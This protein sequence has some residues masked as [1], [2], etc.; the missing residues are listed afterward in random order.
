MSAMCVG[1]AAMAGVGGRGRGPMGISVGVREIADADS[2]RCAD[3]ACIDRAPWWAASPSKAEA[4]I[5]TASSS[6]S[7]PSVMHRPRVASD[8]DS[9]DSRMAASKAKR[10]C[11]LSHAT[12][13][14]SFPSVGSPSQTGSPLALWD[15]VQPS[16]S[17][18][19]SSVLASPPAPSQLSPASA[20]HTISSLPHHRR[21]MG[22]IHALP[23]ELLARIF[24]LGVDDHYA[25]HPDAVPQGVPAFEVLVS[26][27]CLHWRD[28]ALRTPSLWTHIHFR[29]VP[30]IARARLYLARSTRH[31]LHIFIDSAS[32]AD[33]VPGSSIFRD[34]FLPVCDPLLPHIHRWRSFVLK[35]RD[36]VCKG[37]ARTVLS[38][39]GPAPALD[40]LQLWHIEDW[41][42][43][44][45]LYTAIGPPPVVVF[46]GGL[47]A[48]RHLSLI[49]VNI[50]WE[51]R[52]SPFLARLRSLELALHSDDVR[53]PFPRWHAMLAA[54]PA[55][56]RL[57]LHYSGPRAAG[58]PWAARIRLDALRELCLTDLDPPYAC[59]LLRT[60]DA[61]ALRALRLELSDQ[62]FTPLAELLAAP[63]PPP[64]PGT[65]LDPA[66]PYAPWLHA[67]GDRA[68]EPAPAPMFPALRELAVAALECTPAAWRRLLA[69]MRAV[70]L[71]DADFR[72]PRL[73]P[74]FFDVLLE[75]L[76]GRG[77]DGR[78]GVG[79]DRDR[80]RGGEGEE[81]EGEGGE[82]GAG[83]GAR[84]PSVLLPALHTLRT[85][86]VPGARL[87]ALAVFR[88]QCGRP[89][90]RWL[91]NERGRDA[92][93]ERMQAAVD[94]GGEDGGGGIE[95][96]EWFRDEEEDL[97]DGE[98][99]D[100]DED[101][102]G[103]GEDSGEGSGED[104]G[105]GSFV[106]EG[107]GDG[108]GEGLLE[109]EEE[110]DGAPPAEDAAE[111]SGASEEGHAGGGGG[112]GGYR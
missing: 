28:V 78:G 99:E 64:P 75:A 41:G 65:P 66:R 40:T 60:L 93:A 14:G 94:A 103:S 45:R 106:A 85:S 91:V 52:P 74:G 96:F 62:D 26:H 12:P 107:D 9:A 5:P 90:R 20:L 63:P 51:P 109:E 57:A 39:C 35:V 48:L 84:Q 33:H 69:S 112:A 68:P 4:A 37:H 53:I 100:G 1:A 76:P 54:S 25:P 46:A 2:G 3:L 58:P 34:E 18:F 59:A 42:S 49:G 70:R 82:E 50:P 31:P 7:S 29:A 38:T 108:D 56:E 79:G 97:D 86:G 22:P 102:G 43:P 30:H 61:P 104:S 77:F 83:A 88:R 47:P 72:A 87:A 8:S 32:E 6:S 27:V 95:R 98:E 19:R 15:D 21:H 10:P 11:T 71:L 80:D 17:R 55:L 110:E 89:V 111:D 13:A 92:D 44:E 36:L 67:S 101:A 16:T 105:E 23:V 81:R 73:G 24:E